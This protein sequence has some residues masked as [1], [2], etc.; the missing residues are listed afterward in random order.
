ML[1]ISDSTD[2]VMDLLNSDF[3]SLPISPDL[4][5][6]LTPFG[7]KET[8]ALLTTADALKSYYLS[9]RNSDSPVTQEQHEVLETVEAVRLQFDNQE[10][11]GGKFESLLGHVLV[12]SERTTKNYSR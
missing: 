12:L 2:A 5:D 10:G 1:I 3:A 11:K 9:T 4:D 7:T 6:P 8:V